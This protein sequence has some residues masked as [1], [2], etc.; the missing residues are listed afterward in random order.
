L[1]KVF[2]SIMI[3]FLLA[4]MFSAALS[5]GPIRADWTVSRGVDKCANLADIPVSTIDNITNGM[6]DSHGKE[7]FT[8]TYASDEA[9]GLDAAGPEFAPGEIIV[10]FRSSTNEEHIGGSP[11]LAFKP[12]DVLGRRWDLKG[13]EEVSSNTYKFVFSEDVNVTLMVRQFEAD[14]NVEY[15]EPNYLLKTCLVPN[16]P[17]YPLQWAHH[18]IQS[19]SAWDVETGNQS[20]VIAVVDT[21]VNWTHPDIA[22]NVW[23]NPNETV[24]GIDNDGNGFVD[25]VRGWDFVDNDNDPMELSEDPSVC[26]GTH[27]AGIAAAVG[28]NGIG[29]A[30]ASWNC[31]IMPV[32][33]GYEDYVYLDSAAK[34]IRYAADNGAN[35]ISM[36]WGMSGYYPWTLL[37]AV[38]YA[39]SK[40]VLLIAAAGNDASNQL[41][42][43]AA[44]EHVVAVAATDQ[45]D[46]PA[47]FSNFGQ[48]IEVS[49]PGVQI[50][51]TWFDGSYGYLSGTSMSC[52][53]VAGVA[54]LVWSRFPNMTRDRVR[55]QLRHTADDLGAPGFDSYYGYGRINARRAVEQAPADHDLLISSWEKPRYLKPGSMGEIDTTV[56]NFGESYES[57]IEVQLLVNGTVVDS[58]ILDHLASYESGVAS[59]KW[60]PTIEGTYNITSYVVP[61]PGETVTFNNFLSAYVV[62]S[63]EISVPEIFP[64]IRDAVEAANPG[65][66]IFVSEGTY[67]EGQIDIE[68]PLTLLANGTVTVDGLQ[69]GHVF[70]VTANDVTVN[71]FTILNTSS[72]WSEYSGVYLADV[73][74]CK[75]EGN[76]ITKASTGIYVSGSDDNYIFANNVTRDPS[77]AL[78]EWAYCGIFLQN[79]G[80]NSLR[81]NNLSG[82]TFNFYV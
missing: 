78:G 24:D 61:V 4:G 2:S 62:V 82:C 55:L 28:N 22:A 81:K 19:E 60:I 76:A 36:S 75:I 17:D 16:D 68:K 31:K 58:T 39:Y 66:T 10:K 14:P 12:T 23:K 32:R 43:P 15:A 73:Q 77:E 70:Y 20:V 69:K 3:I 30:G 51:S 8:E 74:N 56:F 47:Q 1:K 46:K 80:G 7:R 63:A 26:H 6:L 21:G 67:A 35:I 37:D 33:A 42:Y 41:M 49:A 64:T 25:D 53:L 52:P 54:A 65:D 71:G 79:S 40:G 44:F 34:G 45:A 29:I 9:G 11:T 18:V 27:C 5:I 13:V 48:W 72:W 59:C 57:N 50:Y 38:E